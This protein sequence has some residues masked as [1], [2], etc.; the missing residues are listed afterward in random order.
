M[1]DSLAY[2]G[3]IFWNLVNYDHKITKAGFKELNKWLT[4]RDYFK[5]LTFGGTA[6]STLRHRVSD[7]VYFKLINQ[8]LLIF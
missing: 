8:L 2:R 6:V 3:F 1:K 7:Y 5:D 4:A